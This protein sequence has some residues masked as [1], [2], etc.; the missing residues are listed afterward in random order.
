MTKRNGKI[1]IEIDRSYEGCRWVWD[2]WV[3][4]EFCKSGVKDTVKEAMDAVLELLRGD[5]K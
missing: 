1:Q 5:V 2:V 3:D 4:G